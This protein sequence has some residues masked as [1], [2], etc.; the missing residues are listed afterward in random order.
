MAR[1]KNAERKYDREKRQGTPVST[2][3][4]DEETKLYDEKRGEMSRA[5]YLLALIRKDLR[6]NAKG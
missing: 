1:S 3:L 2:R 6:R 4:T 5:A